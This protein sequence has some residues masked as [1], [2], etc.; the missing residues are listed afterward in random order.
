MERFVCEDLKN[1]MEAYFVCLPNTHSTVLS[2][3][4]RAGN[5]YEDVQHIGASHLIEHLLF[6][7]LH[8]IDQR[9]LYYEMECMGTT[10]RAATYSDFIRLYIEVL[11]RFTQRA[12]DLILKAMKGS[13]WSAQD[14]RKEKAVVINQIEK[15]WFS[16]NDY[17]KS[18]YWQGTPLCNLIMGNKS[19]VKGMSMK[20]ISHYYNLFFQP[21]NCAFVLTGNFDSKTKECI[22]QELGLMKNKNAPALPYSPLYPHNFCQRSAP[23]DCICDTDGNY[24]DVRI[25]FEANYNHVKRE[26]VE[27]L[28]SILGDGVG[29]RLS[30]LMREELGLVDEIYT[31]FEPQNGF[32]I[33]S[34][35]YDVGYDKLLESLDYV[36]STI[37]S[38]KEHI[39]GRDIDA[40][41]QFLTSNW[42]FSYDS[43]E[44]LNFHYGWHSF[45]LDEPF[46]KPE[47]I[48]DKFSNLTVS[49]L[50]TAARKLFSGKSMTSYVYCNKSKLKLSSI[51]KCL[52]K[53]RME[54]SQE[55]FN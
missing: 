41:I 47:V 53:G 34:I 17:S 54:L 20:A 48:A 32:S 1:N 52:E 49:E 28:H 13:C 35:N 5:K 11:P 3:Y 8:D 27:Y 12:F 16:N 22:C 23:D 25:C 31:S 30:F 42:E 2:F 6:R 14:V 51:K 55:T 29:S 38:M 19:K 50:Q 44:A 9:Q 40:S 10:L 39:S 43:P 46:E 45:V 7:R 24:A 26:E 18:V 33:L 37:K 36:F 4:I 21:Q 15:K